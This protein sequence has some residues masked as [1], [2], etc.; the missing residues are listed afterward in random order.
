MTSRTEI[1]LKALIN[2]ESIEHEPQ[3][4]IEKALVACLNKSGSVGLPESQSRTESLLHLLAD[5]L[6]SGTGGGNNNSI[7]G[8]WMFNAEL[9]TEFEW[10]E[11]DFS[12]SV[13]IDGQVHNMTTLHIVGQCVSYFEGEDGYEDIYDG[14]YGGW[15]HDC[16]RTINILETPTDAEF[17]T[18]LKANAIQQTAGGG[19]SAY[20][21][22]SVDELPSNAVDGSMAIVSMVGNR[23]ELNDTL[24]PFAD[25]ETH[26]MLFEGNNGTTYI[27]IRYGI[28]G[29]PAYSI[30]YLL[31]DDGI[32]IAYGFDGASNFGVTEGWTDEEHKYLNVYKADQEAENWLNSNGKI[33][34]ENYDIKQF[35]YTRENGEWVYK[36]EVV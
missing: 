17:I 21:V 3:S 29:P 24:T 9:T 25:E 36:C 32:T 30:M 15:Q 11:V 7:V 12:F 1:L 13:D 16:Y 27:G 10:K 34:I 2:G 4:R 22:T 8:T 33:I 23:W 20:T 35:F 31:S 28:F 6:A 14:E 5:D 19:A 26:Q 18:W